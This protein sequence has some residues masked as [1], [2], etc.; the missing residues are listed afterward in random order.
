MITKSDI[1]LNKLYELIINGLNKEPNYSINIKLDNDIQFNIS[2]NNDIRQQIILIRQS[3]TKS[4]EI[5]LLDKVKELDKKI[6]INDIKQPNT[7]L[8]LVDKFTPLKI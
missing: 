4:T 3:N 2:F 8:I 5:L 6:R 1:Q 7:H